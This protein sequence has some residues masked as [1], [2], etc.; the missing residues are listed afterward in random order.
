MFLHSIAAQIRT[1]MSPDGE[2]VANY[3]VDR[4]KNTH[5]NQRRPGDGLERH[6]QGAKD[7]DNKRFN[8]SGLNLG[9][10]NDWEAFCCLLLHTSFLQYVFQ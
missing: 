4:D 1:I 9:A 7:S 2:K 10:V 6:R 3:T 5:N 8:T